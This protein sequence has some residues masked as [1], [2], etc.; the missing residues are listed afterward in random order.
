MLEELR[1]FVTPDS[2]AIEAAN[3]SLNSLSE[4]QLSRLF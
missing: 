2:I 1:R 3:V 4:K